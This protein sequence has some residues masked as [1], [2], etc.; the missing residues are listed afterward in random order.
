MCSTLSWAVSFTISEFVAEDRCRISHPPPGVSTKH[1]FLM[2]GRS[3]APHHVMPGSGC[4]RSWIVW[5]ARDLPT[6]A[7]ASLRPGWEHMFPAGLCH[8]THL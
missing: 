4:A 3:W 5:A 6:L 7:N 2:S 8:Y 1:V